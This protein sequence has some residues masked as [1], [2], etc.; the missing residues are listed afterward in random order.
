MLY[1]VPVVQSAGIARLLISTISFQSC[2]HNSDFLSLLQKL[3]HYQLGALKKNTPL[4][5]HF[6]L[7]A[8]K[9]WVWEYAHF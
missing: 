6:F 5:S 1:S 2:N 9:E 4:K 8:F 3:Y 7:L